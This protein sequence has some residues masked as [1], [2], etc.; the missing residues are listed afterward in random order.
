MAFRIPKVRV[1]D[2]RYYIFETAFVLLLSMN[3]VKGGG[4]T[5]PTMESFLL[6]YPHFNYL[7]SKE[8]SSLKSFANYMNVA[9]LVMKPEANR[10]HLI[11]VIARI[12]D[13]RDVQYIAGSGKTPATKRRLEIFYTESG[14]TQKE[15]QPKKKKIVGSI[16]Q[17][18]VDEAELDDDDEDL[19][20]QIKD[21]LENEGVFEQSLVGLEDIFQKAG[22]FVTTKETIDRVEGL[23]TFRTEVVEKSS[24]NGNFSISTAS[25]FVPHPQMHQILSRSVSVK[26]SEPINQPLNI[27]FGVA[28]EDHERLKN[29]ASFNTQSRSRPNE[30]LRDRVISY[31]LQSFSPTIFDDDPMVGSKRQRT[32][33]SEDILIKIARPASPAP[34]MQRSTSNTSTFSDKLLRAYSN[35]ADILVNHLSVGALGENSRMQRSDTGMSAMSDGSVFEQTIEEPLN[36]LPNIDDTSGGFNYYFDYQI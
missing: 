9:F 16:L 3:P 7:D 17:K 15:G 28:D 23:R 25:T 21:Q 5:Y 36:W 22:S 6:K 31:N 20:D 8:R 33:F 26:V 2:P 14:I 34:L 19:I 10:T 12:V 18:A 24:K 27:N 4:V 30:M 29:G 35:Q 13:G 1:H 32:S 11:K